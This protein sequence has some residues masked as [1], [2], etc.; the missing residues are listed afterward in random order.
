MFI[1]YPI[2][3]SGMEFFMK[4]F[5][6]ILFLATALSCL[7][8]IPGKESSA[9]ESTL[10]DAAFA[11]NP[12]SSPSLK[13]D[14]FN[15]DVSFAKY[16]KNILQDD[17][18]TLK[19]QN[20]EDGCDVSFKS[21][22]SSVLTVKQLSNTSCSYTGAGYGTAKITATITKTTAFIF[23]ERKTIRATIKVTP[24][25]ASVMF[26]QSTKKIALDKKLKLLLTIRPSISEEVPTFKSLNQKIA[27]IS[28]TG[29]VTGKKIGKTYVTATLLNGKT[30]K[31]KIIV[32]ETVPDVEWDDEPDSD[33]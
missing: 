1:A 20:L 25:A 3:S 30:A 2:L 13:G 22:D 33:D 27:T 16:E 26:R 31:C 15:E 11:L 19:I 24:K 5:H 21:S 28:K 8:I 23:K 32:Q 14:G 7:A 10:S 17:T 9:Q 4:H 12:I 18:Y 29:K 6:K